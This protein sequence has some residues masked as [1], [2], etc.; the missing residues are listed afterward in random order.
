MSEIPDD[1]RYTR[2]HEWLRLLP[3]GQVEVGI[4]QHAQAA[5]GDLVFADVPQP[6]REVRAGEACAVVESVKAASDIYSPVD[7]VVAAGNEA[8][9]AAPELVNSD[10]YGQGWLLRIRLSGAMPDGLLSAGD[11]ARLLDEEA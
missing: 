11:Y 4:T 3:D 10:P 7:G 2:S 6:G 1:L 8:V 9:A 5:L